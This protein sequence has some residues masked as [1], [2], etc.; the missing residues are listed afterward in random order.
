ML[1]ETWTQSLCQ[2]SAADLGKEAKGR[3]VC[4]EVLR[5]KDGS[6][7]ETLPSKEQ[8]AAEKVAKE[9]AKKRGGRSNRLQERRGWPMLHGEQTEREVPVRR[10]W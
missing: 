7:G 8:G 6:P 1:S 5:D 2:A 3:K 10:A 9:T 4:R